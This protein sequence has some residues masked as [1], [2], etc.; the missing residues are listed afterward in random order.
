VNIDFTLPADPRTV[1]A[2]GSFDSQVGK[3]IP[4]RLPSGQVEARV[5]AAE[6]SDDGRW[7]HMTLELPEG[8]TW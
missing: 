8:F 2:P 3:V 6:V 1:F 7:V 5:V 4:L